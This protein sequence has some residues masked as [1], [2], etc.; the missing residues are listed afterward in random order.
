[1]AVLMTNNVRWIALCIGLGGMSIAAAQKPVE[2]VETVAVVGCVKETAPDTWSLV[3]ASDPVVST[4]NAPSP[5][6]RQALPAGG[7]NEFRLIGV[8]IFNLPAH[9]DHTVIIKG[10]QIKATPV[11]R[12]NVTSVTMVAATCSRTASLL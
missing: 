8:S 10:L 12:L 9:R 6:E 7:K 11:S 1:M 2:K 3:N 5:K 4:A